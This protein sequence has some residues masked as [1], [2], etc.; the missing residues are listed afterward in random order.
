MIVTLVGELISSIIQ[1]LLFSLIPFIVW[2]VTARKKESFFSWIGFKKIPSDKKDW[3]KFAIIGIVVSLVVGVAINALVLSGEWNRSEV[4]GTGIAGLPFALLNAV[5]H[6][7]LSEEIIFRGFIQKRLQ[8]IC[9]FKIATV[10]QSIVFG[11]AHIVLIFDKIN[12]VEGVA[13]VIFPIIPAV[14]MTYVNEK[15]ADGSII[16][17][18]IMHSS[19]N[20]I[21]NIIQIYGLI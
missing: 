11:F 17:S 7:A 8:N 14:F 1:V 19:M 21:K 10:I 13:L 2:L 9:G 15:K 12:F 20:I 16:P 6:T 5:V 18:W 4:Y 3:V